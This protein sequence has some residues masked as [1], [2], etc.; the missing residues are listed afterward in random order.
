MAEK[1]L[2]DP[3]FPEDHQRNDPTLPA[4]KNVSEKGYRA[5]PKPDPA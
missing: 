5:T 2:R 3:K 4:I 1:P